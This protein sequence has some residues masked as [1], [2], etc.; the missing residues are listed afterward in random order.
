MLLLFNSGSGSTP[1]IN[2]S[3]IP[4]QCGDLDP[5]KIVTLLGDLGA[6]CIVGRESHVDGGVHLHAFFL[7]ERKFESRNVRIFDVDGHHPNVVRGYSAPEK[8][9]NYATKDG[10][11]VAGGL[12]CP[13][14]KEV[15][16][17]GGVWA[18]IILSETREEFFEAC[19]VLAPRALLCSFTSL[20]TYADWR[21]RPEP[22]QYEHPSGL[23]FDTT[24]YP[25]LDAWVSHSLEGS[26]TGK[27]PPTADS[28]FL[29]GYYLR[30]ATASHALAPPR[31]RLDVYSAD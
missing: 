15:S 9:W 30:Y 13:V 23:S 20:R 14:R 8:G 21:Y 11:V 6:E 2:T 24:A 25:E 26:R 22:V 12:E 5:W 4:P 18:E 27:C 16:R 19:K 17:D 31:G 10:D 7:F 1:T 28:T 29:V 3:G